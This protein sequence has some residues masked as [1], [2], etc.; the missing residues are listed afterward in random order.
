MDSSTAKALVQQPRV[1]SRVFPQ[2]F[3]LASDSVFHSLQGCEHRPLWLSRFDADIE[4]LRVRT[5]LRKIRA[6]VFGK[7]HDYQRTRSRGT[8]ERWRLIQSRIAGTQ[9]L[10]DVGC[11]LGRLAALAAEMGLFA[12]GVEANWAA[13]SGARRKYK[14]SSRLAYMRFIV[15][16][17]SVTAL[18][19]CDVV[20]CLSV[21]HQWHEIFGHQGAQQILH[22]LGTKARRFLFFEPAS[23][24]SKYRPVPPD[25]DDRDECSIVDYNLGMLGGLFCGKKV[26]FV[27]ATPANH[28]E[29]LRHLFGI[30]ITP[31]QLQANNGIR[32]NPEQILRG[33][34][35]SKGKLRIRAL[36]VRGPLT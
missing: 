1:R 22:T 23:Q 12:I 31:P 36:M 24:Q 26:E 21:Y 5:T 4:W 27:A 33:N 2:T 9:S 20:L 8:E 10:L 35:L 32:P 29:R 18:P 15:T 14:A 11:K 30:Q 19:V 3:K 6:L 28:G 7:R 25:Y 16:P 17:E 13:L 34:M